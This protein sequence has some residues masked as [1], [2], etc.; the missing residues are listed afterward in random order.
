MSSDRDK[1]K[2]R[3]TALLAKTVLN[4]CTEEEALSAAA[5][6]A[7]LLDRHALSMTDVEM[8]A[9]PCERLA[10][11]TR[12]NKRIPLDAC[13]GAVAHFCD[14][15]VWREKG[16]DGATIHVFFGLPEDIAAARDLA[17][18]IDGAV[19]SELGRYKTSRDYA[20]FDTRD[21]HLVNSSFA[22]GMVGS[23]A[24]KLDAMKDARDARHRGTGRDLAVVKK[25]VVDEAF[26]K[27]G[28]TVS[29]GIAPR[30]DELDGVG[31]F[32]IVGGEAGRRG[33]DLGLR[34]DRHRAS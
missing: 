28:L 19:R 32:R 25:S 17:E 3:I 4:G 30:R 31:L 34:T 11:E 9:S 16:A 7:E 29:E 6:V 10:F 22:L 33:V 15:R 2:S 20:R 23:V 14:C 5:K 12:R 24:D 13:I 21:R 18:T 8:R 26:D 27:L 1:L